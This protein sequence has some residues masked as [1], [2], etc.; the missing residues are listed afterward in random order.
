MK[1]AL[2]EIINKNLTKMGVPDYAKS[3][4]IVQAISKLSVNLGIPVEPLSLDNFSSAVRELIEESAAIL[5][6]STSYVIM[7]E[8][9]IALT[10]VANDSIISKAAEEAKN[11]V[12]M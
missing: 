2:I 3:T 1:E 10:V 5:I 6:K 12:L 8:L 9:I 7:K 11:A 4:V